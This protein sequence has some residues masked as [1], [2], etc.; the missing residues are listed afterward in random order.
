[1]NAEEYLNLTPEQ[2]KLRRELWKKRKRLEE[3]GFDPDNDAAT[4]RAK[5]A[6]YLLKQDRETG[7]LS[8]REKDVL[9]GLV[10]ERSI[11]SFFFFARYVLDM[12]LLT[13]QTHLKW[14][15][16]IQKSI[17]ENKHRIM[18]LKPRGL[19]KCL[20]KGTR[21]IDYGIDEKYNI[22]PANLINQSDFVSDGVEVTLQSGRKHI[23]TVD[24]LFKTINGWEHPKVGMRVALARRIP[25]KYI[26]FREKEEYLMGLLV[27]DGCLRN[28]TPRLS[29]SNKEIIEKLLEYGFDVKRIAKYDYSI[30][31]FYKEV[32]DCGLCGSNSWTKFIP[33]KYEGS[34][35]FL[36]GLFDA[37]ASITKRNASF[38]FVTVS[39]RLADDVI[40]NLLY[41]GIV[42]RK[43][44]YQYEKTSKSPSV[45]CFHVI[46]N[47]EFLIEYEKYIGF[48]NK[49]KKER[50]S[51]WTSQEKIV[52]GKNNNV[53]TIPGDWRNFLK[54][55]EKR[56][57]RY[58]HGIRID[59]KHAHSRNKVIRCG[60]LLENNDV[61]EFASSDIFWDKI[62]KIKD[63][64]NITFSAIGS[65]IENY[66]SSDGLIHH[67]TTLYGIAFILWVWAIFS[68]E[69]RIFYTSSNALL[70]EEISD[71]ITQY[72]GSEKSET[73]YSQIFGITKDP[74]AKNTSDIFN[75]VG[76]SG[77]GFSLILRTSGGSTVGIHPN[78]IIVDDP[79][80]KNDRESA[81][82]RESK[83]RWF[84]S[85]IPLL[86]PYKDKRT[87][88]IFETIVYVGTR[89]HMKD[90]V[91][92]ILEM[93]EKMLDEHKWDIE[94]ESIVNEDGTPRYPELIDEKKILALKATMSD[95]FM[96][97]QYYNTPLTEGLM[98]FDLKKL[99]LVRPDQIDLK[100]GQ[101]LCVFDPSLGKAHSDYPAVWWLHF[102]DNKLTFFD[103]IDKKIELSLM[104]HH[105]ASKNAQYDCRELLYEDNG[106]IL[107]DQA[108]KEAHLRIGHRIYIHGI[109]HS[110]NKEERIMSMQ[111]DMYSGF[112][113]FMSDYKERYPEAMNQI[114]FYPVYGHD[115]FPDCAQIGVEHFRK[116]QFKFKRYEA[117]I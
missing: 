95:E 84:D 89:W 3:K 28:S 78:L 14:A 74:N 24:H 86:V 79:L 80:D 7:T 100:V 38:V 66:I 96:A 97:C 54:Y 53:D 99:S 22:L 116:P 91:N 10:A 115:D 8:R 44:F 73:L 16:D 31:N 83:K 6:I 110:T 62:T 77:K 47:S 20:A 112:V 58:E 102:Y 12:D 64:K 25:N 36:R 40:R 19:Y 21:L 27:G 82:T 33:E 98:I 101:I 34:P 11:S 17:L 81:A 113:R 90:L 2:L 92:Y 52:L 5:K 18:R 57:L 29:C 71:K 65:D 72:V 68:P 94:I 32:K 61:L 59:N 48:N 23:C 60:V 4:E 107:V 37:D 55:D 45:A 70:L 85:L 30:K 104:V 88:S 75:I 39:E 117:M 63:V 50:L 26:E 67:N 76:R 51:Y 13:E 105:I 69:I 111:P 35:H 49:K 108:L 1:M 56:K 106:A 42:A 93:N 87:Q 43:H 41:F 9:S 103:A 114:V 109:H 15:N 46:F